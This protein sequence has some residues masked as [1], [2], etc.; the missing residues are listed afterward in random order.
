MPWLTQAQIVSKGS[1]TFQLPG[2]Q[3]RVLGLDSTHSDLCRFDPAIQEDADRLEQVM[4][5]LEDLYILAMKRSESEALTIVETDQLECRMSALPVPLAHQK[6]RQPRKRAQST[7]TE[8]DQLAASHSKLGSAVTELLS[9]FGVS[10]LPLLPESMQR[11][12]NELGDLRYVLTLLSIY[13]CLPDVPQAARTSLFQSML[14]SMQE[15]LL[16]LEGEINE[17]RRS[18]KRDNFR[19]GRVGRT[20]RT[21]C[22]WEVK[23]RILRTR[24]EAILQTF[25]VSSI[26]HLSSAADLVWNL[27]QE[28][29]TPEAVKQQFLQLFPTPD[30]EN[31]NF[32]KLHEAVLGIKQWNLAQLLSTSRNTINLKDSSGRSVLHWAAF[33]GNHRILSQILSCGALPNIRDIPGRTAL[34]FA[35]Q[36]GSFNCVRVLLNAGASVSPR[37][38]YNETPLHLAASDGR[39]GILRLLL[40]RNAEIDARDSWEETPLDFAVLNNN[41]EGTRILLEHEAELDARDKHGSTILLNGVWANSHDALQVLLAAKPALDVVEKKGKTLLHVIGEFADLQ[42]IE[43]FLALGLRGLNVEAK[44]SEGRSPRAL[45]EQRQAMGYADDTLAEAFRALLLGI[46]AHQD[47]AEASAVGKRKQRSTTVLQ[48]KHKKATKG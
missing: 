41:A 2:G 11:F 43:I 48:P 9:E 19:T 38:D 37:D 6:P 26:I 25:G 21:T 22:R 29:S 14:G 17:Q 33:S 35:A 47:Q 42:T 45:F 5:S 32:T 10:D 30:L 8:L 39:N 24:R 28:Y 3:E 36:N 40:E 27:A 7:R 44:E 18:P 4:S 1:A 16:F 34:H 31:R 23:A 12:C 13:D 15:C 46:N 20:R